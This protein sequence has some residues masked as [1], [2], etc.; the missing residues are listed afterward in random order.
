M[1][2][3]YENV[4][5]S[6]G[7]GEGRFFS[8]QGAVKVGTRFVPT[9]AAGVVGVGAGRCV[10]GKSRNGACSHFYYIRGARAAKI[11]SKIS[12]IS[13]FVYFTHWKI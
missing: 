4:S 3:N 11:L 7:G 1:G 8:E 9:F 5:A 13:F 2:Y 10:W 6:A 12:N